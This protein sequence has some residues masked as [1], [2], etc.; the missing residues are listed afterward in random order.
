MTCIV[1]RHDSY[2]MRYIY[3]IKNLLNN[4]IYIGQTKNFQNRI[5][6]HIR[7]SRD[8]MSHLKLSMR[9]YGV[10][11]FSFELIEECLDD[12]V[13][14]R[15]RYWIAY[16]DSFNSEK[17]YNLTSG[18]CSLFA[19][20]EET[21][22]KIREKRALQIITVEQ[23]L[24][25]GITLRITN[26]LDEVK[27]SRRAGQ[28]KRPPC[29]EETKLKRSKSMIEAY[30]MKNSRIKHCSNCKQEGHYKQSCEVQL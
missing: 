25:Q 28:A 7:D 30:K 22:R 16:Y 24:K 1:G 29:T 17:G 8:E 4:K 20:S 3:M 21:K 19:H 12:L 14:D 18:G 23:R 2:H 6:G 11:N 9:N 26:K 10:E 27:A 13:N 15:E 5:S